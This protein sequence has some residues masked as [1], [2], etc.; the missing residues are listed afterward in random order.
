MTFEQ[1]TSDA[2]EV[3]NYLRNR[4]GKEKIY[5]MAH[6]GGTIIGIEAAAKLHN[7]IKHILALDKL[8]NKQHLKKL[9]IN[10]W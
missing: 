6:S 7:F 10:I 3:S 9:L 4:F 2:I 1:L 8:H 5:L